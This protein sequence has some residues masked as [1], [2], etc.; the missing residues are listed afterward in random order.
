[1]S[2]KKTTTHQSITKSNELERLE[3]ILL[4]ARRRMS[5]EAE[6]PDEQEASLEDQGY[7]EFDPDADED[8]ADK[9]LQ[10][11]DPEKQDEE[12]E[13]ESDD[14]SDDEPDEYDEYGPDEDEESHQ[15]DTEPEEPGD[16][17]IAEDETPGTEGGASS[18]EQGDPTQE[19]TPKEVTQEVSSE[20][21]RFPQPSR[22]EIAEM[23]QHTRPWE[24]NAREQ[25]RLKAEAH[26]NPVLHHQGKMIEA[27][28]AA[29]KSHQDAYAEFQNSPDYQNADPITQME[30]D[31]KF[32]SDFHKQ[33]PD[34]LANAAK[35]HGQAHIEGLQGQ[36]EGYGNKKDS[37]QHI[38]QGGASPET[39][40]SVEEGMQH[41]G[42][43]KG[44]EGTT[45]SMAQDPATAFAT[46]HKKFL[47]EMGAKHE[48]TAG[49]KQKKYAEMA[50]QY[51]S[52]LGSDGDLKSM[53][54]KHSPEIQ[55]RLKRIDSFKNAAG[56]TQKQSQAKSK[57]DQFF[58]KY[59]PLISMHAHKVLNK[60]GLDKKNVDLGI[61]HEAGMHGLM[62]AINDYDHENPGKASFATHAGNKI[63]GLMQTAMRDQIQTPQ[64][65]TSEAK[66]FSQKQQASVPKVTTPKPEGGTNE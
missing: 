4:K 25:S 9:W 59:H 60:L 3:T 55:D 24:Q 41:A 45:G 47:D 26:K 12:N 30:M 23:R 62:Q 14:E 46:H 38:R 43:A 17:P 15:Q 51:A 29:H 37:I 21:S 1:M 11:N 42:G 54:G 13:D 34:Y 36:S 6:D 44:E 33:N 28:N 31:N 35:L 16:E 48:D 22:E 66:K 7:R 64:Q 39:P 19:Q 56:K 32:E 20:G 52:K 10:E 27:R 49:G 2:T 58:E 5:D 18:E 61:L 65:L 8:D 50:Q 63:S 57:S 53:I 40:M